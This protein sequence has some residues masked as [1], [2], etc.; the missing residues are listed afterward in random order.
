MAG[1]HESLS[2]QSRRKTSWILSVLGLVV[3]ILFVTVLCSLR[4]K[5]TPTVQREERPSFVVQSTFG[6]DSEFNEEL[7]NFGVQNTQLSVTPE[8]VDLSQVI[9]GSQAEAVLVLRAENGPLVFLQKYLAETPEGGF[10]LTGPCMEKTQL[11]E[12]EECLL[13][14]TWAPITVQTIQNTLT[15]VWR[16]D[17]PRVLRDERTQIQLKASST[18]S[19]EC[20]CCEIEKDK[21]PKVPRKVVG[22]DGV[23]RELKDGDKVVGEV[24]LD[25]KG[26]VVAIVEPERVAL[27]LKNEYLGRVTD[28]RTVEDKEGKILGRLLGDDTLVDSD[29]NVLGAAVPLVSVL[30][31]QGIVIGKM[32]A[33]ADGV[34]VVDAEGN[35]IGTPRVD[36][37]VVDKAGLQIGMLRDWGAVLDLAGN[38]A[39]VILPTGAVMAADKKIFGYIQQNGFVT[40]DASALVGGVVP[41]GAGVGTGCRSYGTVA[42]TGQVKDSYG[43]VVGR[44]MLDGAVVDSNFNEIGSVVN[45]GLIVNMQGDVVG[46]VNSEGKGVDGK[47]NLM[48]CVSPNGMVAAAKTIVGGVLQKGYV[49]GESCGVVGSV[50]PDARVMSL[51]VREVGK[52]R[53]DGFVINANNKRIGSVV[54]HGTVLAEACRLVGVISVTGQVLNQQNMSVGCIDMQKKAVDSEGREIGKITPTGPVL[55]ADGSLI[56]RALY[57]GH[58]VDKT[59]KMIDCVSP[60]GPEVSSKRGVVLDENGLPTGW[61]ALAGKCYND[62]N[63]EVGTI[64]F[65]GWVSDKEGKLVGF[66]PSDGV[67]FGFDGAIL[68]TYNQLMGTALNTKGEPLGRVMPDGTVL[69]PEGRRILGSLI[70]QNT[71]FVGLDGAVLGV[72]NYEGQLLNESGKP[73]GRVLSDGSVYNAENALIGGA[74]KSGVVLSASGAQ[75]GFANVKGDVLSKGTRIANLLPNGLAVTPDNRVLGRLWDQMAVVVSASGVVGPVVPRATAGDNSTYQAS[76]YD[77]NGSYVGAMSG[78]GALLNSDG[79]LGGR[80]VPVSMV[81]NMDRQFIGWVGFKGLVMNAEGQIIGQLSQN[82]LVMN[83]TGAIMGFVLKKGTVIDGLGNYIG[84]VGTDGSVY[85]AAGATGLSV[86]SSAYLFNEDMS[87]NARVIDDGLAINSSGQVLGWTGFSGQIMNSERVMGTIALDDRVSD[88]NGQILASYVPLGAPSM[89]EDEKMC[90]VVAENGVAVSASGRAVGS[91]LAPDYVV[92]NNMIAGR[93]RAKSLFVRNLTNSDLTGTTDLDGIVYR[94]NTSRQVGTMAMNGLVSDSSKKIIA[95]LVGTGF[96]TSNNLKSL[97]REDY[98]GSVWLAGKVIG[99]ASAIDA[100]VQGSSL[101]GG[102]F[103]PAVIVDRNGLEIGRSD[104]MAAVMDKTGKKIASRMAFYSALTPETIWAGGPIRTG[105]VIDDYARKVGVVAGDGLIMAGGQLKG[106]ILSDG[107]AAAVADRS[108]Y[109]SMPYMGHLTTQGLPMGYNKSVLGRTTVQG[110]LIDASDK[111]IFQELDD[112]TILGKERPLEGIVLPFRSAVSQNNSLLGVLDGDG[113][114]V[115]DSGNVIGPVVSNGAVKGDH[116]LKILGSLVPE[117]LVVNNCKVVGQTTYSGEVINGQGNTV[118]RIQPDQ[119]AEDPQGK[120]LGRSVRHGPV[121]SPTHPAVYLGRTMPDSTVVDTSGVILGCAENDKIVK[122]SNGNV[123]GAVIDRGPVFNKAGDMYGRV[124]A[125]GRVVGTNNEVLGYIIGD[126]TDRAFDFNGNEIGRMVSKTDELLF[127]ENGKFIGTFDLEGYRKDAEGNVLFRVGKDGTLYDPWGNPIGTLGDGMDYVYLYD[128][129]NKPVARLVGCD[130]QKLP[131]NEKMGSVLANGDIRD[132]NN[133]LILTTSADGK[134]FNPDGTQYGR[135]AGV[136]LDLRRCGLSSSNVGSGRKISWG[137]KQYNIDETGMITDNTGRVVGGWDAVNNRPYIWDIAGEDTERELP[138]PPKITKIPQEVRETFDDLQKKRRAQMKEKISGQPA[139]IPGPEVLARAKGRKDKDWESVGYGKNNVSTWPVDMSRVLLADK[140]VPAVLVRSIDSRYPNV[141]VTAIVE[142]HI[143]AEEG[144]NILIPAGS[145][146]IGELHGTSFDF[147]RDQAAKISISWKRLIRPDGAAFKF[148][149]VSGDAQ[150]RGGVAAYL[151]LQLMKKFLL[152]FVST[153]GEWPILKMTELNEKNSVASSTQTSSG[154]TTSQTA[155][156]QTREAFIENFKEMWGEL[157]AMAGEVP[158]I[159]YV[160][161]GTRLTAFS[162]E[163]L[164]LRSSEDDEDAIKKEFGNQPGAKLPSMIDS[165]VGGGRTE[166]D[167]ENGPSK[168]GKDGGKDDT[169]KN[170]EPVYVPDDIGGRVVQP[171]APLP[172]QPP[173]YF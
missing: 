144:R 106:R 40:N 42:L 17:N 113:K 125:L 47:G 43:Q 153:I 46:F 68:G 26:E 30:D 104:A 132:P 8:S 90:A 111:V 130:L 107:S 105:A 37:S 131:G 66:M 114:V 3:L 52:V 67:V 76:V 73:V 95:G 10:I 86:G 25:E 128:M 83:S 2:E 50:Y 87:I 170:V 64:A 99:T 21:D 51:E 45:Q 116:E 149:A 79:R 85:N 163:D 34:R 158:N 145:H 133:E 23:E 22:L 15:I 152:P 137:Q 53:A 135:F 18:D 7:P 39:G 97:G 81:F 173:A 60:E 29:F 157:M 108:V 93:I 101:T 58:V 91:V 70:A 38:Y 44:V 27:S 31:A 59:G 77:K 55:A 139:I 82:G 141:P 169:P 129:Q 115:D 124:D 119:W 160:P 89:Q 41:K 148:E 121:M 33:D 32:V 151:D 36:K 156:A 146:L 88:S 9:L 19:K 65:N 57:N 166:K 109:N 112:A 61:T 136:G 74:I 62:R 155:G 63:E 71:T 118:G 92:Q 78:Y 80:A 103:E 127:D 16:E 54:P 100:V 164:W 1:S 172:E 48:G 122:D 159:L 84:R 20:V 69:N 161:A 123:L 142:R 117:T 5:E 143:Y 167:E 110:D 4:K 94:A 96:A 154:G 28:R 168:G 126:G 6:D 147:G 13:K 14:V 138:P 134:V 162:S 72:L 75:V 150:G 11:E 24:I 140:A 12:G 35:V 165:W 171:V 49:S 56:G 102:I 120:R 98:T